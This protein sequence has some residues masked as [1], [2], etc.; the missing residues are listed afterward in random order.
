MGERA[1]GPP[2]VGSEVYVLLDSGAPIAH[3]VA[4]EPPIA[5]GCCPRVLTSRFGLCPASIVH[6]W[7]PAEGGAPS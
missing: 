7:E 2:A 3:V 6:A 4:Y 5:E 1:P